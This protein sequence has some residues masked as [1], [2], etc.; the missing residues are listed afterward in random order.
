MNKSKRKE[1]HRN[2]RKKLKKYN[3][4]VKPNNLNLRI[5]KCMKSVNQSIIV[6]QKANQRRR[7]SN[8]Q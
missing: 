6:G 8:P 2:Q 7:R 5:R 4:H 3:N 1:R